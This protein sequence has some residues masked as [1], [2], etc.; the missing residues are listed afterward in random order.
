M[1]FRRKRR[2]WIQ[3]PGF[4]SG[5]TLVDGLSSCP[6]EQTGHGVGPEEALH[7]VGLLL[8]RHPVSVETVGHQVELGVAVAGRVREFSP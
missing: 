4:W 5:L 8:P 7:L 2:R 6:G 1:S 3:V